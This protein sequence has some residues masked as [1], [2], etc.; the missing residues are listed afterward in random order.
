LLVCGTFSAYTVTSILVFIA[1]VPGL[2]LIWF[3]RGS[4]ASPVIVDQPSI[5]QL[6]RDLRRPGAVLF[7]LL[8]FFQFGNEWSIAGWLPIFLIHR[9]GVSPKLSLALLAIYWLALL[10]GRRRRLASC[11]NPRLVPARSAGAAVFGCIILLQT[12]NVFGAVVGILLRAGLCGHLS[13]ITERI[14]RN[15]V[16]IL[17]FSTSSS[18]RSA[19]S[20]APGR[21]GISPTVGHQHGWRTPGGTCMVFALVLLVWLKPGSGW[22][23]STGILT[24]DAGNQI[25]KIP[26]AS[27]S[28]HL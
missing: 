9:L 8:L 1:M 5:A 20:L 27:A 23:T 6:F 4:F 17:D 22:V 3:A 16:F 14:G 19:A 24:A 25:L 15:S 7:A 21:S 11:P 18:H 13:L 10:V 2:F 28:S 12:D 26:M